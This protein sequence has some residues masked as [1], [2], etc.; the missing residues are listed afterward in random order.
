MEYLT[1]KEAGENWGVTGR[2]YFIF[3]V[4]PTNNAVISIVIIAIVCGIIALLYWLLVALFVY[5]EA[6]KAKLNGLFWG[7]LTL[8]SNLGGLILFLLY[9]KVSQCCPDCDA[10]QCRKNTHCVFCGAKL[11]T[12]CEKCGGSVC[13]NEAFCKHCGNKIKK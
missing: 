2:T 6:K 5:K 10:V 4:Q 13:S 12:V 9:K 7:G 3:D 8:L 11:M 1:V